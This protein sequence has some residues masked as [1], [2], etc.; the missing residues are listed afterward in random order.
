MTSSDDIYGLIHYKSYTI[1][2]KCQTAG[3]NLDH[4]EKATTHIQTMMEG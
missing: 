1:R 2:P 3:V 4:A